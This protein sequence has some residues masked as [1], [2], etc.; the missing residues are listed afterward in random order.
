MIRATGEVLDEVQVD[1]TYLRGG[2]CLLVAVNGRDGTVLAWQ[3]CDTEKRV[4]WKALLD[5][6]PAPRV[7]VTDG[8]SGLA[9]ALRECWPNTRV[10]RCL[11][12]VQRNI[13]TY[14][15]RTPRT[16]AGKALRALSLELTRLT[17]EEQA[18]TWSVKL[19]DWHQ[20]Y[21]PLIGE[22]TYLKQARV[23]PLGVSRNATWWWTHGRLRKAYRLLARLVGQGVLFTYL[24]EEF[25]GLAIN[26]TTNTIEGGTNAGIKR[27][28]RHHRGMPADHRRRACEWWCYQ[29]STSPAP[30]RT[31]IRPKHTQPSSPSPDMLGRDD[32]N[33]LGPAKYD[34]N[35][36]AEEGLWA[37]KGW[38][39]RS[40]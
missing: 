22:K 35:P 6:V 14:L 38:A 36:T 20:V 25:D 9:S 27:L 31:L 3:W 2:W 32:N 33:A 18:A 37:R 23:R 12:H 34:T 19:H 7:V 13:R 39:G 24:D 10:Q 15:T 5:Q 29:H 40:Q 16:D 30:P 11:V 26:S 1:G 4:A 17:T 28:L 21:G 8:G